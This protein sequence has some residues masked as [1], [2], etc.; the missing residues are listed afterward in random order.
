MHDTLVNSSESLNEIAFSKLG[1]FTHLRHYS[2][3]ANKNDYGNN[4]DNKLKMKA[5]RMIKTGS[6]RCAESNANERKL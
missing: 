4:T 1:Q 6:I 3:L 2:R 5:K